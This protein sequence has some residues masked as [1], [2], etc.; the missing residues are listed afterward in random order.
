MIDLGIG[1][2]WSNVFLDVLELLFLY[3]SGMFS[4]YQNPPNFMKA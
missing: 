4:F 2:K 1:T 3:N